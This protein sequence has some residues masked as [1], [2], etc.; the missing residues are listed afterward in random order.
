[1]VS[2]KVKPKQQGFTIVELMIATGVFATIVMVITV[3]IIFIGRQFQQTSTRVKLENATREIHQQ[4]EQSIAFSS[5]DSVN[6]SANSGWISTCIGNKR[7]TYAET[8]TG[9]PSYTTA[10]Y[11]SAKPGLYVDD[12]SVTPG[13]CTVLSNP[14]SS[15]SGA[16]NMLPSGSKVL[17]FNVN[18]GTITTKLAYADAD[19]LTL[20]STPQSY[21]AVECK[22]LVTG[23]EY[24]SVVQLSSSTS[25]RITN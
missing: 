21:S 3:G 19:L 4:V 14:D 5:V 18:S 24:C 10:S 7:Y 25:K 12:I 20:T 13:S 15:A 2:N 11:T 23:K 6:S 9:T 1:M 22:A 8:A 16:S 17:Y